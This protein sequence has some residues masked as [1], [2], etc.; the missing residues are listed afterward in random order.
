MIQVKRWSYLCHY[1]FGVGVEE[2]GEEGGEG[3]WE[4][5]EKGGEV[6]WVLGKVYVSGFT[7]DT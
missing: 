6:L 7:C 3:G 1:V 4:G 5:S 2:V